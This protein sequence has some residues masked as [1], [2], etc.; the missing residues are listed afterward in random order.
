MC[1]CLRT[2]HISLTLQLRAQL[3][4][5]FPSLAWT[6]KIKVMELQGSSQSNACVLQALRHPPPQPPGHTHTHIHRHSGIHEHCRLALLPAWRR[7]SRLEAEWKW[8][9]DRASIH[10]LYPVGNGGGKGGF[11]ND[12]TYQLMAGWWAELAWSGL[13]TT[14]LIPADW[15]P[16]PRSLYSWSPLPYNYMRGGSTSHSEAAYL[17]V[18]C[19]LLPRHISLTDLNYVVVPLIIHTYF[20]ALLDYVICATTS[21]RVCVFLRWDAAFYMLNKCVISPY[22]FFS[23]SFFFKTIWLCT[24]QRANNSQC[25]GLTRRRLQSSGP[26]PR[27]TE[28]LTDWLTACWKEDWF[29]AILCMPCSFSLCLSPS[30]PPPL[31]SLIAHPSPSIS[32]QRCVS[33]QS[34]TACSPLRTADTGTG[35][36]SIHTRST[37]TATDWLPGT[38]FELRQSESC[39]MRR[40]Q[41]TGCVCL[42]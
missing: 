9:N 29:D 31:V 41:N 38:H 8:R 21:L 10:S 3:T 2:C 17:T 36:R 40:C 27:W 19:T 42:F 25:V 34:V 37:A 13:P 32:A 11:H 20:P 26:T 18:D 1:V 12:C 15:E 24:R 28:W 4:S 33:P 6:L 7:E 22:C 30:L 14:A 5:I 16:W 23:L 35:G 39:S